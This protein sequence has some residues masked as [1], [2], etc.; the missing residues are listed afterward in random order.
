VEKQQPF[1]DKASAL[2]PKFVAVFGRDKATIFERLFSARQQV[3]T[4]T[5]ALI[6]DYRMGLA[7]ENSEVRNQRVKWRKQIFASRGTVDPEDDVGKLLQQFRDEIEEL[8]RPI[9]DRSFK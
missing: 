5:E 4:F 6:D 2:E 9:V 3:M 1:F 8:C 7:A